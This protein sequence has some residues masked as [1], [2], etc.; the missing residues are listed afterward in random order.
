MESLDISRQASTLA[1]PAADF[2]GVLSGASTA[3]MPKNHALILPDADIDYTTDQLISAAFGSSGQRWAWQ[4]QK[5]PR[6]A[7]C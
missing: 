7:A 6:S 5:R 2:Q 1:R 4:V 3:W